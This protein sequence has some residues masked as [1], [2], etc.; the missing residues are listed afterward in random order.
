MN[1]WFDHQPWTLA[2]QPTGATAGTQPSQVNVVG[3]PEQAGATPTTA[4]T[5]G[6]PAGAGG[7]Q[8]TPPGGLSYLMP[9]MIAMLAVMVFTTMLS[10]RKEKKKR[11]ELMANLGRQDKV[12]VAGGIIGTVTE[13][14]DDS[15]VLRLEEG[16]MRVAK[17]A[18]Q[19]ILESSRAKSDALTEPK[20]EGKP[21]KV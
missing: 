2:Q 4:A 9:L 5:P 19:Q 21:A 11:A 15:V 1:A 12:L 3:L 13:V 20:P 6:T 17:A 7:T 18:V 8:G 14:S 10:G 16:R